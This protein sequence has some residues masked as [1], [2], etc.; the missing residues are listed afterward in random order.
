MSDESSVDLEKEYG[1]VEKEITALEDKRQTQTK[2]FV[3]LLRK[4][5][6][7]SEQ[8]KKYQ[9]VNNCEM[10]IRFIEAR[11]R[12]E[13]MPHTEIV[14]FERTERR[15]RR[16]N[17]NTLMLI[18][19]AIFV[20]MIGSVPMLKMFVDH[21]KQVEDSLGGDL[22]GTSVPNQLDPDQ[23]QQ[24]AQT[25]GAQTA[26]LQSVTPESIASQSINPSAGAAQTGRSG[27]TS[28]T[29]SVE[30]LNSDVGGK[31]LHLSK[32]LVPGRMTVLDFSS[33]HCPA[34]MMM[35]RQYNALAAQM[36]DWKFYTVDVDRPFSQEI[37]FTSPVCQQFAIKTLPYF[38]IYNGTTKEAEGKQ[39]TAKLQELSMQAAH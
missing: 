39:A 2:E 25:T 18:F 20:I 14:N 33:V 26:P 21:N 35:H 16:N 8:L 17:V 29:G 5:V 34:C 10:R 4:K 3:E 31:A 24:G 28:T 37:D 19:V 23:Q 7:L 22:D 38:I 32:I 30:Q 11:M 27:I 9:E 1:A 12:G 15:K 13:E 6:V 36:P